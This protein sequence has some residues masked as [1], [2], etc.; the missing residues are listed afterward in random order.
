L[1]VSPNFNKLAFEFLSSKEVKKPEVQK[2]K[3]KLK[4]VSMLS[5]EE[6]ME[7][8]I[9]ASVEGTRVPEYIEIESD[10]EPEIIVPKDPLSSMTCYMT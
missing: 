10:P 5:E 7:L 4:A 1:R 3:Q 9:K 6:Q 8:A 2:K